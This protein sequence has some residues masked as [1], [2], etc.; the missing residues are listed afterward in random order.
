MPQTPQ[1]ASRH[2]EYVRDVPGSALAVLFIHGIMGS[3][4]H[5]DGL[6]ALVPQGVT[7]HS[8]LLPGHG[9]TMADFAQ[10]SM[11]RWR[12]AVSRRIDALAGTHDKTFIVAHSMGTLFAVD[13]AARRPDKIG[14]LLLLAVPLYLKL[15]PAAVINSAKV[16]F[17]R[18]S[19]A[20]DVGRAAYEACSVAPGGPARHYLGCLPRYIELL[21][22]AKNTRA[23]LS[24]LAVP[25]SV[26]QSRRDELVSRRSGKMLISRSSAE[27]YILRDSTHYYCGGRDR[28]IIADGFKRTLA[29]LSGG[30]GEALNG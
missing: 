29:S 5:F 28:D 25:T 2:G 20:D 26:Y 19:P 8:L 7:V 1:N 27:V 30:D 11:R 15:T 16:T 21:A 24:R 14:A 23:L 18:I 6:A 10:S 4:R 3:P 13:A 22:E 12:D 17:G 9:G